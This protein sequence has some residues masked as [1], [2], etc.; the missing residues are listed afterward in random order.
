MNLHMNLLMKS[1]I[2]EGSDEPSDD[3]FTSYE[4][5][6]KASV[7]GSRG[8]G[9][10][11]LHDMLG[12]HVLVLLLHALVVVLHVLVLGREGRW[13]LAPQGVGHDSADWC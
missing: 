12:M 1:F 11:F 3:P 10:P 6:E 4:G 8:L 7:Q 9:G 2:Y 5:S 13:Y